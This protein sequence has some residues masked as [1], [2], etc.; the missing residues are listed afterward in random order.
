MKVTILGSGTSGG[1]PRIGGPNGTGAWG[2][3]DPANPKNSRRRCSILVERHGK[4]LLVDTSPDLRWQLID[5][6]VSRLDAVLWTHDHA[7]QCHGIDDVRALTLQHGAI[8]AW[9]DRPTMASLR[10]RF[11]YCFAQ[12]DRSVYSTLYVPH[13]IG[14]KPFEAAGMTVVPFALDHGTTISQGFR[15]GGIGYA[16]DVVRMEEAAFDALA[17]VE[18]LIVDAMRY[19]PHPTHAHLDLTLSW[20]ERIRPR[21]AILTNLHVDMDYEELNRATPDHVEP[22]Y[23]GMVIET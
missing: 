4:T 12:P 9:A 1:V 14:D 7:D 11:G 5:A 23:D 15:F 8:D 13:V 19:R 3:C 18:V 17:G 6:G 22:A 16:N 20:I 10:G 2:A 21:R